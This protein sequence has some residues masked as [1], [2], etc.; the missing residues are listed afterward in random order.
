MRMW[1]WA[2]ELTEWSGRACALLLK[3]LVEGTNFRFGGREQ[4]VKTPR[5]EESRLFIQQFTNDCL[6]NSEADG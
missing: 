6:S 2:F 5:R 3:A 1:G 4:A